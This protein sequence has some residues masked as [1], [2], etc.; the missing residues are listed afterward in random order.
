MIVI[1]NQQNKDLTSQ[2]PRADKPRADKP[3]N[4]RGAS[5][6]VTETDDQDKLCS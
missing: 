5:I 4:H 2:A 1:P 3:P 6:T